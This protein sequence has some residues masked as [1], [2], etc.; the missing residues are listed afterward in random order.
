MT[1]DIKIKIKDLVDKLNRYAH[2]YYV[3][4]APTV[5]DADYDKLYQELIELEQAYPALK[6][7]DSPSQRVGDAPL[8]EFVK[9]EHRIPMLSL[10]N[11]FNEADLLDFD[12]RIKERTTKPVEYI[13]ELKI[14][15]L[16][17][18]LTYENGDF[19]RGATREDITTNLKT[20]RSIPLSIAEKGSIEVRGEAYMPKYSFENLNQD[21]LENDEQ[22]FANPRNAAAGSLR[23]L[24]SKITANRHLDVFM[25]GYGEW[26]NAKVQSTHSE[27]LTYLSELGLKTNPEWEKHDSIEEV[28]TFINEWTEKRHQLPYEIDGIVVKVNDL[29][30][31]EELGFTARNPR[32]AIAYK[33]PAIEAK[34]KITDVELSVGRTGVVTPTAVLDPVLIDGS[35]VGRATLHN[36]DQIKLLDIRIGDNIILKKAGDIIPKVVR[37][38][39]EDRTGE[40]IPY[41]MPK[42][43][44]ACESDLIHLEDEVALRCVN[45]DCPAQLKEGLIHFVSREAMDIRG[46]GE[47]VIE[48]LYDAQLINSIAD[49]YTLEK[50]SLLTLERMGEKSV[51]NLLEAI[52]SSK[53]NSLE[54]LIFGLGIRHIGTKAA[55]ILAANF[56]TMDALLAADYDDIV[57]I[58]EIGEVIAESVIKDLSE[59]HV[60]DVLKHLKDLG[61]DMTYTGTAVESVT[62]ETLLFANEGIVLT[63]RLAGF[64]RQ[65]AEDLMERLGGEVISSVSK[66]TDLVV[67]GEASGT[68]YNQAV[69][70]NVDIWDEDTFKKATDGE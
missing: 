27:R 24:D 11:A 2:E 13:C 18:S 37:V 47:R 63:G 48:Q 33:F 17:I 65:D 53:N 6:L 9:V 3:L 68:K 52:E 67:A 7:N 4:D 8:S 39:T 25:F 54:K 45:P 58:D 26:I 30:L 59:R 5:P 69:K 66:N 19:V 60:S 38:I 29:A 22:P 51:S 55:S 35:T 61:I 57:A 40:E 20:I 70:L 28:I 64:T 32:W 50:S 14:D 42:V 46:L 1:D 62:E 41:E 10:G 23:Q 49:I 34:T 15:G 21:R 12:R 31:Q 43:C 56:V 44:P 36:A 16:A